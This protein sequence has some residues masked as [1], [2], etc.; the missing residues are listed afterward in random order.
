M[1]KR[2]RR[3]KDYPLS[4]VIKET[5]RETPAVRTFILSRPGKYLETDEPRYTRFLEK[6]GPG[7]FVMVWLP[8]GKGGRNDHTACDSIPLGISRVFEDDCSFA[9]TVEKVGP[10]TSLLFRYTEGDAL[11]IMGPFGRGFS[12]PEAGGGEGTQGPVLIVAGGVGLA[13]LRYLYDTLHHKTPGGHIQLLYGVRTKEE[14]LYKQDLKNHFAKV[15]LFSDD[16]TLGTHG[17]PTDDLPS[18]LKEHKP[19]SIYVCGPE[20]ML[21]AVH[22]II[23]KY[24]N[25]KTTRHEILA[26]YSLETRFYCGVGICGLCSHEKDR[27]GRL[28]CKDGPVFSHD[29]LGF[30]KAE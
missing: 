11:G 27:K 22:R 28:V 24:I 30:W 18:V 4:F 17:F 5:V 12:L 19:R 14:L 3:S 29:E 7:R 8:A 1:K 10:T 23:D 9:I 16:G 15:T 20:P 2:S 13:P 21:K 25:D 26:E 6:A